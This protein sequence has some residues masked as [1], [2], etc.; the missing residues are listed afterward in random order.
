MLGFYI[1]S[2]MNPRSAFPGISGISPHKIS[3]LV[4]LLGIILISGR[5]NPLYAQ[6]DCL[7]IRVVPLREI[8]NEAS[9]DRQLLGIGK[10]PGLYKPG[11]SAGAESA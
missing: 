1:L 5:G 8:A 6:N 9:G 3:V 7:E 11:E 2:Y 10:Y 4:L